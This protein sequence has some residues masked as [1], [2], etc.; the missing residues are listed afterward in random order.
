MERREVLRLLGGAS[1]FSALSTDWL[2]ATLRAQVAQQP[3]G[4][5]RTLSP[6]QNDIV[7]AMSETLIPATETPGAK[8]ARVNE[9]IDLIL[10]DWATDGEKSIFLAGLDDA[11][12]RTN[13]L[14]GHGFAAAAPKEQAAIVGILDEELG[15]HMERREEWH[16]FWEI[17]KPEPFFLQMR[18]LTLTGYYTSTIGQEQELKVEI[19][20][21][22]LHGCVPEKTE[23]KP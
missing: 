16:G 4:T 17:R 23:V 15:P 10:T 7:V 6:Q 21:G 12:R 19:I 8:A 18:R 13:D 3:P 22:A 2:G 5:L 14:F 1:V 20:P 9:F 11:D